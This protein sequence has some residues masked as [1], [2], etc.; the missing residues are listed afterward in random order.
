MGRGG[1]ETGK[2][3]LIVGGEPQKSLADADW[4]SGKISK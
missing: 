2:T 4:S 3:G 1:N